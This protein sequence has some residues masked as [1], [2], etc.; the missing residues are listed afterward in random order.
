ME[1]KKHSH[2]SYCGHLFSNQTLWPRQCMD[3]DN[4]SFNNPLPT[5]VVMLPVISYIDNYIKYGQLIQ[6]R[7][8]NPMKDKWALTGGYIDGGETWQHAAAREVKEELGLLS[9]EKHYRLWNVSASSTKEHI[10]VF[11]YSI[12]YINFINGKL[13]FDFKSNN[14]VLEVDVMWDKMELAFAAHTEEANK[15]LSRL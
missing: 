13:D 14:E 6:K 11:C 7:A 1:Y 15:F 5:V 9:N 3:C 2:C 12:K 10:L 8:I 4:T